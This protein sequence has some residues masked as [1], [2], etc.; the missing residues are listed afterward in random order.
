MKNLILNSNNIVPGS[1]NSRFI[2]NFPTTVEFKNEQVAV[3]SI[4]MYFSVQNINSS[5][6][7]NKFQ[8][9]FT[10]AGGAT[11]YDV[12]I[13]DGIYEVSDL[14]AYLQYVML[15]NGQ[16]LVDAD[17][18]Y[19]YFIEIAINPTAYAIEITCDPVPTAL[20][21]GYT[22][23]AGLTF[24]A[25]ATTPQVV[26][27]NTGFQ[28]YLGFTP[29]TYPPVAQATT[30]NALSTT[31]P[32]VT[33]VPSIIVLCSL[34]NNNLAYPNTTLYSF[35]YN[36]RPGQTVYVSPPEYIFT[37]IQNGFYSQVEITL[38]NQN[39]QPIILQD[40]TVII[41]LVIKSASE[42]YTLK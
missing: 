7:N 32:Q 6:N 8:Y 38:V 11:T 24:P 4:N 1:N 21:A 33:E 41:N 3:A 15:N 16:Y 25:V 14:N 42:G 34:L 20:P 10:D 13:P 19:V 31:S 18:R 35:S 26:I 22:N 36:G 30:Y 39:Y 12:T 27:P 17:G 9:I 37:D 28:T 23:P 40:P 29:G 2:Y 5:Y